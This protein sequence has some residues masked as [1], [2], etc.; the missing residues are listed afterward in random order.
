[1]KKLNINI[2]HIATLRQA[3]LGTEPD[4]IHAAQ[5]AVLAGADG[6]VAHL[7]EDRRHVND[8]DVRLIR[9]LIDTRFDL[10]MSANEEIIKIALEIVP[11][12]VTIVPE[13]RAELT[14]EGGLDVSKNIKKYKSLC[15]RMNEKGI[16]VSL[17]IEPEKVQI[18]AAL[19]VGANMIE[20]HTGTYANKF[21]TEEAE[22]ELD[23][24]SLAA[25]YAEEA[26]LIIAA[27]H[28]LNYFNIKDLL[29]IDEI[30]EYSI[31]HSIISRAAY[32]G[33][34]LAVRDMIELIKQ[35]N[36]W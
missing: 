24:I 26:G 27:G 18:D 31:G 7:R 28:G 33:L 34:D 9:E 1:M 13:K 17:F 22:S 32:V 6:I 21:K 30:E 5:I 23:R 19:E 12:L 14:T 10:E 3:R 8:R 16:V 15:N 25:E 20:I 29:M 36:N 4:P 35:H 11:D 2:D